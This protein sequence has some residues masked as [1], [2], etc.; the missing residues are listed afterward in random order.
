MPAESA[1]EA[2]QINWM[3]PDDAP[4]PIV[5]IGAPR[6]ERMNS[7]HEFSRDLD[8]VKNEQE[9]LELLPDEAQEVHTNQGALLYILR[10]ENTTSYPAQTLRSYGLTQDNI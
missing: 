8:A 7:I 4:P 3:W 1:F 5:E 2:P 10:H 9:L 6:F